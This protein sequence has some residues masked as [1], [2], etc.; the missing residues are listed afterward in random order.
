[1]RHG[2]SLV[3]LLVVLTLIGVLTGIALPK[4]AFFRDRLA[5]EREANALAIAVRSARVE[6]LRRNRIVLVR[7][8]PDSM[9][10]LAVGSGDTTVVW[11]RPGPSASGTA[12]RAP[13][14]QIPIAPNGLPV[15]A[16][17]GT[18]FYDRGAASRRVI[19]SRYGRVR[20][21]P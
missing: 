11:R 9:V 4:L 6:A 18:W 12:L 19:I 2:V 16:A 13:M 5:V 8:A 10:L 3:E 14:G 1:M 21:V 15:G 20:V 7:T 17:N